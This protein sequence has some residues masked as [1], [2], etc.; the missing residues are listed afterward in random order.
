MVSLEVIQ[1]LCS[2]RIAFGEP[3]A[4]ITSFRIGGPADFYIEPSS[5]E[6]VVG[7]SKYF[8]SQ[9]FPFI[10]IGNGS[11]ILVSDDGYRGAVINLEKG[12]THVRKDGDRIIAGAGIRMSKFVDFC[13]ESEM[14]GAEMLAG[15]PG[16]LGGAII[17]NAGAY[18]GAISDHLIDVTIVRDDQILIVSKAEAGFTYRTSDLQRDIII[19]ASFT[20]EEGNKEELHARRKELIVKRNISQPTTFPNAGSIFKNPSNTFAAKLIEETGLKG[21]TIGGAEVSKVHANFIINKGGARAEE[22]VAVMRHVRKVVEEKFGVTLQPEVKLIGF[23]H[24]IFQEDKIE[25]ESRELGTRTND[26]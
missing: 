2:G 9:N 25:A 7:L 3:L 18:E 22:V 5:R 17:M 6:E 16:T 21:F 12:F 10:I 13:I 1:S 24:D 14:K 20:F 23:S 19:E 26:E 8:G 15:I 4:P 11:N